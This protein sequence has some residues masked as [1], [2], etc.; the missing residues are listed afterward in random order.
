MASLPSFETRTIPFVSSFIK[1]ASIVPSSSEGM[2][3][4]RAKY[5]L[6]M[7]FHSL[8]RRVSSFKASSVFPKTM[9]PDVFLSKRWAGEG[10]K[11]ES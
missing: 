3:L 10:V 9:I 11:E 4:T 6:S 2:P 5:R 1:G 7:L 8:K